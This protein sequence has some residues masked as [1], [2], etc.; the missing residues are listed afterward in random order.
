MKFKSEDTLNHNTI[1][2]NTPIK[3]LDRTKIDRYGDVGTGKSETI[4]YTPRLMSRIFT[5]FL[6]NG[7][8]LKKYQLMPILI[9]L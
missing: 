8:S 2:K 6:L 4:P 1:D 3:R 7:W 9:K 5:E